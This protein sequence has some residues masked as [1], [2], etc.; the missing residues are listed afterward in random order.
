MK[1]LDNIKEKLGLKIV[2][3]VDM[4][5]LRGAQDEEDIKNVSNDGIN[6][7]WYV[8]LMKEMSKES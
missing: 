6:N 1:L 5:A 7:T 3:H 2:G 8:Q 4:D